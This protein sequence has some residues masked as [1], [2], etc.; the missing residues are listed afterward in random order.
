MTQK[1]RDFDLDEHE[2]RT[3]DAVWRLVSVMTEY[4]AE[5]SNES[6]VQFEC[7]VTIC[8]ERLT[9]TDHFGLT[10][11][12]VLGTLHKP[13]PGT[14]TLGGG[15]PI[16]ELIPGKPDVSPTV[17]PGLAADAGTVRVVPADESD[18]TVRG[19]RKP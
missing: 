11:Q 2:R 6:L 14:V 1:E 13:E 12:F 10:A 5:R 16:R 3:N 7:F 8:D 19:E 4:L 18:G 17:P 9:T 15:H